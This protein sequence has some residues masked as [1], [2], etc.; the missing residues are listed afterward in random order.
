MRAIYYDTETTGIRPSDDR[1][2]EIAA[3]DP[4]RDKTFV[5]LVNPGCPIPP[6]ASAIHG[7]TDEMVADSPSY[8]EVGQAFIE[9]C[10][11]DVAL[12][13]HNNDD[14]DRH[15]LDH[16]ARRHN[17]SYPEWAMIDSLKWSR[18]YRPDLPRHSLQ[19]L[20]QVYGIPKNRAHRALDDVVILHKVFSLMIDDLPISTVHRLLYGAK[21]LAST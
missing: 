15:F 1:I 18:K 20:R 21:Q 17:L 7:I 5:M 8:A 13:A 3:F 16:E 19:Y 6:Q 9:F 14:F 12:I 10:E 11:G 2:V 4:E